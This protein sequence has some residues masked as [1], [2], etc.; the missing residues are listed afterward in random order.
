MCIAAIF[1]QAWLKFISLLSIIYKM[2]SQIRIVPGPSR[3]KYD[4]DT[5]MSCHKH[6]MQ[7]VNSGAS[8]QALQ[9]IFIVVAFI[10]WF[11]V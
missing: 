6:T 4:P 3:F 10:C 5:S 11:Q 8:S 1:Q 9:H 2:A 7:D